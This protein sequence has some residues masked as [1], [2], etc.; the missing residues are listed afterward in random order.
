MVAL[1]EWLA[2]GP[3]QLGVMGDITGD[4]DGSEA[5]QAQIES[6]QAKWL[7]SVCREVRFFFYIDR[8]DI[9]VISDA[10]PL[11]ERTDVRLMLNTCH[12]GSWAIRWVSQRQIVSK[13][14]A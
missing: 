5:K 7:R 4:R 13:V 3:S 11:G 10:R 8:Y 2:T 14:D 9:A 12:C 1:G 6:T